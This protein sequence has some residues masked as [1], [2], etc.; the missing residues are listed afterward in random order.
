LTSRLEPVLFSCQPPQLSARG[1]RAPS[2]RVTR[3]RRGL[4]VLRRRSGSRLPVAPHGAA[5]GAR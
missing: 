5:W 3:T 4:R 2:A 1:S